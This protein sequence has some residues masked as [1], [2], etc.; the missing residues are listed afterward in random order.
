MKQDY[1]A[2]LPPLRDGLRGRLRR[3]H[4]C[5]EQ[6]CATRC[7]CVHAR[8]FSVESGTQFG[9]T[10]WELLALSIAIGAWFS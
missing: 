4:N 9:R 2:Y 1:L 8:T 7:P 3:L 10:D 5:S 6:K